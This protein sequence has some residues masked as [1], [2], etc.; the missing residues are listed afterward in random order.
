MLFVG[1]KLWVGTLAEFDW[2]VNNLLEVSNFSTNKFHLQKG[3]LF[4]IGDVKQFIGHYII[5]LDHIHL[6]WLH[7]H[8]Q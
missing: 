1:S 8:G 7:Y 6:E 4:I 2:L 3:H 5:P